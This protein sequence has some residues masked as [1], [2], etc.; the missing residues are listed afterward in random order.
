MYTIQHLIGL[1]LIV[2]FGKQGRPLLVHFNLEL[3]SP[4]NSNSFVL[5]FKRTFALFLYLELQSVQ[6]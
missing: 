2:V 1:N 6:I 3:Q 4:K 5:R